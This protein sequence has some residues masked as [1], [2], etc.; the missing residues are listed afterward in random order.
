MTTIIKAIKAAILGRKF[1]VSMSGTTAFSYIE[2]VARIFIGCTRAH[3]EGA[4]CFNI[5]GV[6]D[7][8]ERFIE[9]VKQIVPEAA[10]LITIE[11]K[12]VPIMYD[13]DESALVALLKSVPAPHSL[14]V[15]GTKGRR[16]GAEC[17]C[18]PCPLVGAVPHAIGG[19]HPAHGGAVP[20]AEGRE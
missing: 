7:T 18:I 16:A 20:Q 3:V 8:T 4:P 14:K 5:R 13:V 9:L 1:T 17:F 19:V 6:I 15:G 12:E 2:D 10:S 11:G